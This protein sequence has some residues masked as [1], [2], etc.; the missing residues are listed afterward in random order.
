MATKPL[1]IVTFH[2]LPIAFQMV[3]QWIEANGHKLILVVTTPGPKTRP[4]PSYSDLVK[5][6]PRQVDILVTTRLRRVAT[7][8]IRELAPDLL[9]SFSFPYRI[10]PELCQIPKFGAVNLHPTPLPAYRGPNVMRG[11][12]D[13]WPEVG[14]TLHWIDENY[15]TG[16]ILSKKTA[17]MPELATPEA[18]TARWGPTML[19]AL[20]EGVDKA[21]A[22][23]PGSEQDDSQASYAAPFGEKEYRL[24]LTEAKNIIL[25]RTTALNFMGPGKVRAVIDGQMIAVQSVNP[26]PDDS[27]RH[28]LGSSIAKTD[29]TWTAQAADGLIEIS[30]EVIR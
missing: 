13:G 11:V 7:P 5:S 28:P 17:A 22:G 14:A 21:V 9:L 12:Y 16:R 18:V 6:A 24:D 2:F 25:R 27:V 19:A 10:T 29:Q 3:S 30:G 26:L 15:D 4:T 8:L 23:D 1:R 20:T